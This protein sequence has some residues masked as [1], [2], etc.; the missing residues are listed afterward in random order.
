MSSPLVAPGAARPRPARP[1]RA[2]VAKGALLVFVGL[3]LA[4]VMSAL[5]ATIVATALPTI[6]GELG[7]MTRITWVVTAYALAMVVSMPLYGKLGDLYGRK[8]VLLAAV[9]LFL[10]AS[11]ACGSAQ[12]LDQL[13]AARFVQGIGGGGLGVLSMAAIADIV[14]ARQLGRWLGYQGVVFA[15]SSVTGPVVGGLFVD[16][17]DWRW[18]FYINVPVGLVSAGIIATR[19]HVGHRRVRHRLDWTGSGLLTV[20]LACLVLV[21]TLGGDELGWTS[22]TALALAVA[23]P[24]AAVLFVRRELTAPEPVLPLRLLQ[25]RVVRV[26]V[27]VN[28]TSG[29]LLWC[30]IFFVPLFVQEVR[31]ASPTSAGLALV[32][33]MFGAAAGTVVAGRRVER[34]GRYR[35]WPLAGSLCMLVG[36]G[37]LATMGAGTPVA[38]VALHALILGLGAGFVMQPSLLAAQNSAPTADLGTATSTILVFRSLG[39]T[40]VIP[41]LGGV[42]NAGLAGRGT[43]ADAFAHA[44]PLVFLATVPLAVASVVIAAR[45]QDVPLREDTPAAVAAPPPA[46]P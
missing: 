27:G 46:A 42:L 21:V 22:P 7:G 43:D 30:G 23:V 29:A 38:V 25:D 17:L 37:L 16:H 1:G 31:L 35:R 2:G 6:T 5:D 28:L 14:P 32:P 3:Q 24:V 11:V 20:A 8:R 18:A 44:L 13:I 10:V 4:Q 9:A 34:S 36:V 19:L 40:V 26:C 33:L 45:L 12:T 41:I 15:I 39:S